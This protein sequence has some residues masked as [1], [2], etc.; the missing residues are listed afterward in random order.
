[1]A[2]II[3]RCI[4]ESYPATIHPAADITALWLTAIHA[5]PLR[6]IA[7]L[8]RYHIIQLSK[9]TYEHL[10]RIYNTPLMDLNTEAFKLFDELLM[11][12]VYLK[13]PTHLYLSGEEI[14]STGSN[15]YFMLLLFKAFVKKKVAI[16]VLVSLNSL[17]FIEAYELEN[18]SL[19]RLNL[20]DA[21]SFYRL[22]WLIKEKKINDDVVLSLISLYYKPLLKI[23]AFTQDKTDLKLAIKS[24][25]EIDLAV[26]N[27][28]AK[29][30]S[31]SYEDSTAKHLAETIENINQAF[32]SHLLSQTVHTLFSHTSMMRCYEGKMITLKEKNAIEFTI[33]N[34]KEPQPL[35]PIK[36]PYF[37]FFTSA[38]EEAIS[39]TKAR[40]KKG[41]NIT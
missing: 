9:E 26:I 24:H 14:A 16:D 3:E 10:V 20:N 39:A 25:E 5:S 41:C 2:I 4:D 18:E 35:P 7:A 11:Q 8:I 34:R 33:A 37:L 31:V 1:M 40:L 12:I 36:R 23:V 21:P 17:D 22:Q 30:L 38:K 15:D 29:K 19:A 28:L 6:C 13:S 32:T 27:A